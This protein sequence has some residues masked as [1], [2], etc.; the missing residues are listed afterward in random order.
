MS[1]L[2][3]TASWTDPSLIE[4]KRFYPPEAKTPEQRLR[5]YATR[6]PLVE[7]D[8]SYYALPSQKNALH[9]AERTPPGFVF[10][11]KSF[12]LFT[13]HQTPPQALPADIRAAL[14]P[15]S[16][17]NVYYRDVPEELR[18]E[19]W[20]RFRGALRPLREAGRLG[21]VLFQ[22]PPWFVHGREGFEHIALCADLL[23]GHRLA[24][25]FR[26]RSWLN[27]E[28]VAGTLDFLRTHGLG[29]V[30]VDEPQGFSNSVPAVWE[31]TSPEVAVVRLHG[32]NAATWNIK[33]ADSSAERFNYLYSI[34]ELADL[35][36]PIRALSDATAQVHVVFNNNMSHYAQRN[37]AELMGLLGL[38]S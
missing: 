12:R 19:L 26:H 32:R 25:E 21:A 7:V 36:E 37:A 30:V 29:H 15:V 13:G 4:S 28:Q 24:V 11:V 31:A 22:F 5:F 20:S 18:L 2:I 34:E 14:G 17:R 35:A 6:F 9:W 16:K 8:S 10:D 33:G 1:I 23:A 38:K 3:G 27:P